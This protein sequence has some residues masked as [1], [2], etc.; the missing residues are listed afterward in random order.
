MIEEDLYAVYGIDQNG[1]EVSCA[2]TAPS[3]AVAE[4]NLYMHFKHITKTE[5]I[6]GHEPENRMYEIK[7]LKD[8]ELD[9]LFNKFV[10]EIE[11]QGFEIS[12]WDRGEKY[13]PLGDE[14][15]IAG[16]YELWLNSK[17]QYRKVYF[18]QSIDDICSIGFQKVREAIKT[19]TPGK[20]S[21]P[22]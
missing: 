5:L 19:R 7:Y 12:L 6:I 18:S 13:N 11:A 22:M 9:S 20:Y 15:Y 10:K 8:S 14:K 2:T 17:W 1:N 4:S 21:D 3:V 16:R